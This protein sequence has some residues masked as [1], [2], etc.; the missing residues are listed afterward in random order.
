MYDLLTA[1]GWRTA[2]AT[3]G[4]A[5]SQVVNDMLEKRLHGGER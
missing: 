5:D 4:K 1:A 3:K 2:P